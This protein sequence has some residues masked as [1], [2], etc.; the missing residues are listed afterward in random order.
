MPQLGQVR[1]FDAVA[2]VGEDV[3]PEEL[4]QRIEHL[5]GAQFLR[6]ADRGGEV[7]PEIA[8]HLLPVDL[9]IRDAVELFLEIRGEI[10][11]HIAAE[12][13]SK[14]AM[15]IRPLSSGTRR[16]FSILT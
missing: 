9:V 16:F 1:G 12:E 10:V 5:G 7:A 13:A 14:K 15:T 4:V 11:L 8:Q 3:R 6:F 2:L